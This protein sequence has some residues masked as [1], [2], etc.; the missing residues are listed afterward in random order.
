MT[1]VQEA[2][3]DAVRCLSL[4]GVADADREAVWLLAHV[5]QTSAG[6]VRARGR[7]PV[8]PAAAGTYSEMVA[9]RSQRE[10]LQYILG[11]EEFMGMTFKVTPAVLIPRLDTETLVRESAALLQGAVRVA[12]IGT[13]S[14]AVAIGLAR[15]LPQA[16]VVAVDISPAA[17]AIARENAEAN[18]VG[19]RV[20]FRVGDLLEPLRGVLFDAI[21]SNPPYIGEAE[22]ECLMPEVRCFEPKGALTPGKDALLYYR[23]LARGSRELLRAGG[24]LAVEVG[25]DQSAAVADLFSASGFAVATH[26]DTGGCSRVVIGYTREKN[27]KP[28]G[29]V[30]AGCR[31]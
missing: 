30:P 26:L 18:G 14:G 5:L 28:A 12:D 27:G 19:T 4:A 6:T 24:F 22:W 20:E 10:P 13:G 8:P 17:L 11:T 15:L 2:L 31:S 3:A 7:E 25:Y 21:V 9:R 23:Q 29:G 1:T 16:Q